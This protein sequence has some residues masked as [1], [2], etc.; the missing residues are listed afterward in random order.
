MNGKNDYT[1]HEYNRRMVFEAGTDWICYFP[2]GAFDE[3]NDANPEY[4]ASIGLKLVALYR[5][6][7]IED[8]GQWTDEITHPRVTIAR[9]IKDSKLAAYFNDHLDPLNGVV[10]GK[11]IV[12]PWIGK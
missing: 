9:D 12:L 5:S 10:K 11:T 8:N 3:A 7:F 2:P 1:D 4:L 6:S